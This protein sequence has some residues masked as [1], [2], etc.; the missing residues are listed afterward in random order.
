MYRGD[1]RI[2][3]LTVRLGQAPVNIAGCTLTFTAS[4]AS[5]AASMTGSTSDGSVSITNPAGGLAIFPV[6]PARTS[7][8]PN[9]RIVL[10]YQWVMID[11]TDTTTT[12]EEDILEIRPNV[13]G[14]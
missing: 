5:P 13:G 14:S 3:Q 10:T 12:L 11:L 7:G 1:S 4:C 2:I 9:Q 8:F 6:M